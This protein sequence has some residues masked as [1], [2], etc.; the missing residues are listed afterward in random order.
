MYSCQTEV[1]KQY[2]HSHRLLLG[3]CGCAVIKVTIVATIGQ[4]HIYQNVWYWDITLHF[5]FCHRSWVGA[6]V[7]GVPLRSVVG[8]WYSIKPY[9]FKSAKDCQ[10]LGESRTVI[11]SFF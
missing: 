7:E 2:I 9:W 8:N 1:T 10:V 4:T 11:Y 5:P 6:W 3:S